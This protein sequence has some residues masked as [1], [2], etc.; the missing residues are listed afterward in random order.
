MYEL[1]F[2]LDRFKKRKKIILISFC[3][4]SVLIFLPS[5]NNFLSFKKLT[6]KQLLGIFEVPGTGF[7]QDEN[8]LDFDE[9]IKIVHLNSISKQFHELMQVVFCKQFREKVAI[10][11][12]GLFQI[13]FNH[14][15][16]GTF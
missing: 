13:L 2:S 12:L 5:I 16:R 11:E 6:I 9:Y 14:G 4:I 1:S 7:M 3:F 10:A 8:F 15:D